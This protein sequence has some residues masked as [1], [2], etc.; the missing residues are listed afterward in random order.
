MKSKD[1]NN[2][3]LNKKNKQ[4]N[5]DVNKKNY[6][7]SNTESDYLL[8]QE[9]LSSEPLKLKLEK[10][11]DLI[12]KGKQLYGRKFNRDILIEDIK[13]KYSNLSSGQKTEDSFKIA[14]RVMIFRIHGKAAFC[15]IKDFSGKIQLYINL[16][17]V[18]EERYNEFLELDIGDW[19]GVSGNVFVTHKGE[20]SINIID[21]KLL[22]KSIR[23]LPE[24]WH[25][26]KNKELRYRK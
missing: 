13:K 2:N 6:S 26:L 10:I 15:D 20:L 18:G 12:K 9:G 7:I 3:L 24:K 8:E 19:V 17:S 25:G 23:I 5:I 21:F 14:G 11:K 4:D 16:K 1:R 22:S